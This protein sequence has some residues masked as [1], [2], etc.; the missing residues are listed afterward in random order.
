MKII[1]IKEGG[2]NNI[3]VYMIKNNLPFYKDEA[4]YSII[5]D[6]LFYLITIDDVNMF[7]LF[8][9]TQTFRNKL[10]VIEEHRSNV[11]DRHTLSKLF[12]GS[13]MIDEETKEETSLIEL[14]EHSST[15]L[16][17]LTLQMLS[18]ND[19]ISPAVSTLFLPML[20]RKFTI[21]IPLPFIDFA[22]YCTEDEF[23][24]LFN[25]EY[26]S[27]INSEIVESDFH[28]IRNKIMIQFTILTQ[29][30]KYN[31]KYDNILSLFKYN[32]LNKIQSDDLY[33]FS[34]VGFSKYDNINRSE[35]RCNIFGANKESMINSMKRMKNLKTPLKVDIMIQLP[36]FYMQLLENLF[37]YEDL[38]IIY[39]SSI[40]NIIMNGLTDFNFK[41]HI[42]DEDDQE[43]IKKYEEKISLYKNRIEECNKNVLTAITILMKNQDT[44]RDIDTTSVFSLLP[45]IYRT[46]AMITIDTSK[47]YSIPDSLLSDFM[48]D[49]NELIKSISEDIKNY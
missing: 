7:E 18:D 38:P 3:L 1:N 27:N 9:L 6:E 31:E 37:S 47:D 32:S 33:K 36:I 44:D 13:F 25:D 22:S 10:R 34:L 23:H 21:Q 28:S 20:N 35:I 15:M 2:C 5:N 8:R 41:S 49:I 39:E 43:E 14:A 30:L 46:N 16:Q 19:V 42:F 45:S 12:P 48:N 4:T 24:R 11:P 40:N 29:I 17:N 26:P